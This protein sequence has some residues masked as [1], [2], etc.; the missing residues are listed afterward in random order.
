MD[1]HVVP[2]LVIK[3]FGSHI[4]ADSISLIVQDRRGTNRYPLHEI[5]HLLIVGGHHLHT[6]VVN[7]LLKGGSVIT[8]CDAD[9][10][11]TGML[12]PYGSKPDE[13]IRSVQAATPARRYAVT[14]ATRTLQ[15]QRLHV[16][17][18]VAELQRPILYE[19]E[20]DFLLGA[21][22]EIE[23]LV[24]MDEIR[25]L[26]KLGSDMY[27]EIMGR[28]IDPALGFRRRTERPHIDP[29]NAMLSLGYAVLYGITGVA[30]VGSHL[31]PGRGVLHEGAGSLIYD[32]L[33]PLKPK[34]VDPVIFSIARAGIPEA[35]YE[36]TE[37]RCYLSEEMT[38]ALMEKLYLSIVPDQIDEYVLDF[39][40]AL[41]NNTPFQI[42]S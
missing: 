22:K 29:V 14:I 12:H 16:E 34:C 15:I 11:P 32:L 30:L 1:S 7:T 28:T 25:R 17:Q 41:I 27:Y 21:V 35:N 18:L 36:C 26:F 4:K 37:R 20:S 8:F 5:Q 31:D 39:R 24:K 2:W 23:Y 10:I 38:G 13:S 3:G 6:S 33:E 19:G 9:G 40:D 42:R